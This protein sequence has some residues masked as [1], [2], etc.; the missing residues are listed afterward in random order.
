MKFEPIHQWFSRTAE[1]FSDE[2]A[3]YSASKRVTYSELETESNRLAN[4]L[5]SSG[6]VKGSAVMILAEQSVNVMTAIL[7]ILKAGCV[8]VPLDPNIPEKR[9]EAITQIVSPDWFVIES[10]LMETVTRITQGQPGTVRVIC[11][12]EQFAHSDAGNIRVESYA[13]FAE[14]HKPATNSLPDDMCYIYFTSGSTGTPKGI[15]GRLKGIDHFVRWEINTFG[16][17]RHTRAA[18]FTAISFDAFLRDMFVPLCTG[19]TVCVPTGR[20]SILDTKKLVE[21]IDDQKISLIHCVPSLFRAVLNED[22]KADQFRSLKHIFLA[23]EP[24]LPG[25]VKR[26][27]DVYGERV[28]LVNLYGPTETTMTKFFHIVQPSDRERRSIPIGKPMEGARGLVLDEKGTVCPPGKVGEI[29][30][31][32][33]FR[34]LGYYEQAEL[35]SEVFVRNPFSQDARD[36]I[37]KTGDLG[38]V[39]EDGNF[40]FLGRKDQQVKIRGVRIELGEIEGLL[41]EH[42]SVKGAAVVDREDTNGHKYL[43]AYVV[44]NNEDQTHALRGFLSAS[45]PDYMLPAAFVTLDKLPRTIN[46]KVDRRA[47]STTVQSV[48]NMHTYVAPRT[49]VEVTLAGI[50]RRLLG[51]D[52]V[53]VNDNFFQIGGHSLL[54]TQLLSRVRESFNV[55]LP[56]RSLFDSPTVAGLALTITQAQVEQEDDDEMAQLLEEIKNLDSAIDMP[57]Y[58][59]A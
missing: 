39:L 6:I 11:L 27:M 36:I 5:L 23:G 49:P 52:Q 7:G 59:I 28:Q 15:A 40:E 8:F 48:I 41:R 12:D 17:D 26:W 35:T 56:L 51:I 54:A 22:L 33:P 38:R 9:L 58:S 24:L 18:Q 57:P 42:P 10:K 4:F 19:G 14:T 20:D 47:L 34:S 50:W 37:Y 45:L 55:G 16:L 1:T 25:D 31:R 30:I 32:T 13:K 46:G 29:Y 53:G 2:T 3:I 43:C 21:W 44:F